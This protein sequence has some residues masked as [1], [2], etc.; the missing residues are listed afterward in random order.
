MEPFSTLKSKVVPLNRANIDTDQIIP[1]RYLK[2]TGKSGMGQ[3]L[4]ADWRRDAAG[5]EV[6][7]FPLNRPGLREANILLAGENFGCGS[8]REHAVW[9]L[10]DWGFRSVLA[11]SFADIFRNNAYKNGLLP[12]EI[13]A[14]V[15]ERLFENLAEFPGSE[16]E[17]D[18][19]N[20]WVVLPDGERIEF[21][22]DDFARLTLLRGMDQLDY[23]LSKESLI[24][25]F[26]MKREVGRPWSVPMNGEL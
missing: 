5:L 16:V 23:L 25:E 11:P 10:Q 26:E 3:V 15:S 21:Q 7:G 17:V 9:A 18:L 14:H 13:P 22:T 4:F 1:A 6:A 2:A 20:E 24:G 12:V 19:V 8:S